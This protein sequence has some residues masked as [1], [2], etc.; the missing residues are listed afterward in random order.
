M[1]VQ[2]QAEATGGVRQFAQQRRWQR[3]RRCSRG[4][5]HAA[6]RVRGVLVVQRFQPFDIADHL[7]KAF[8]LQRGF[9][10][11]RMG[12]GRF[13]RAATAQD[14][15]QAKLIR[16]IEQ[17][18][19]GL[20][21]AVGVVEIMVISARRHARQ[22]QFDHAQPCS[23]SRQLRGKPV[24]T[25]VGHAG[26]P[27]LQI[28]IQACGYGFEQVLEQMVVSVDPA[29]ID[30]AVS[31]VDHPFTG[32]CLQVG[33]HR[34]DA[35]VDHAD[36]HGAGPRAGAAQA[37]HHRNRVLDQDVLKLSHGQLQTKGCARRICWRWFPA[38]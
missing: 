3:E 10:E 21:A 31:R 11:A 30:H 27:A 8:R 25:R 36:V 38:R 12:A 9:R 24:Q 1:R 35:P 19:T 23:D 29:R 20:G 26:Q 22:Q 14:K 15:A 7:L 37:G 2:A 17:Q 4:D 5:H 33:G 13:Q 28:L 16:Q 18:I 6:H 32:L 34:G